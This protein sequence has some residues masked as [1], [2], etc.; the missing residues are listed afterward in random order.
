MAKNTSNAEH[1]A[2]ACARR[3]KGERKKVFL[4]LQKFKR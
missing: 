2:L 1:P 3:H 4:T